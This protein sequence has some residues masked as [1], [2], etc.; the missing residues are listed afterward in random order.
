MQQT[1]TNVSIH[2]LINQ[3][4]T[5]IQYYLYKRIIKV[6]CLVR[7]KLTVIVREAVIHWEWELGK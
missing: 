2:H 6:N 1:Q 5:K 4:V 3:I 7:C